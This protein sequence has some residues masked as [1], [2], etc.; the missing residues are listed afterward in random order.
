MKKVRY[1]LK[2]QKEV[3]SVS[4]FLI[5]FFDIPE[6]RGAEKADNAADGLADLVQI[7]ADKE[8]LTAME[9]AKVAGLSPTFKVEFE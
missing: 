8:I 5:D 4:D 9:V 7:L 1:E 2:N 6:E 3:R